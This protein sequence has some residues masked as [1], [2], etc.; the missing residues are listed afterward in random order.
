M[1][2][3]N[4]KDIEEFQRLYKNRFSVDITKQEACE[5]GSRLIKLFQLL[6]G[7]D[8]KKGGGENSN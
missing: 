7:V 4:D 8:R 3:I 1:V 2:K 6:I 5:K